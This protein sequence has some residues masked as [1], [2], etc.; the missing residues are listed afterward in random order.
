MDTMKK[1]TVGDM[2]GCNREGARCKVMRCL[3]TEQKGEAK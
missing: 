2:S 1:L 3:A